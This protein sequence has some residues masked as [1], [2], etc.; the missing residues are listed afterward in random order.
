MRAR[1]IHLVVSVLPLLAAA[2]AAP[3]PTT[4]PA[5]GPTTSP[6]PAPTAAATTRPTLDL[7]SPRAAAKS[8]QLALAA[9]DV[10]MLGQL[11]YAGDE[12]HRHLADAYAAVI[13]AGQRLSDATR[14]QFSTSGDSG[15]AEWTE[16]DLAA[17]DGA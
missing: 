10:E 12:P 14:R 4:N 7:S 16:E 13:V 8:L 5:T 2:A 15:A 1:S 3:A 9:G 6:T 11:I 17:I